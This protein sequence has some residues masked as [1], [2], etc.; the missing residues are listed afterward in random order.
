MGKVFLERKEKLAFKALKGII[1]DIF[2]LV[3]YAVV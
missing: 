1:V 2:E 3:T